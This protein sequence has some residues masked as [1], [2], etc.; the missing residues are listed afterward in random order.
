MIKDIMK[1][2]FAGNRNFDNQV[3]EVRYIGRDFA[4][5]ADG[6]GFVQAR[7]EFVVNYASRLEM[8]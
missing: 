1:V 6:A 2:I 7:V 5:R 8:P 3:P 4:A